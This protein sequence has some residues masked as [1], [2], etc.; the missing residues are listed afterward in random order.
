MREVVRHRTKP[1]LI[2]DTCIVAT[3]TPALRNSTFFMACASSSGTV[4]IDVKS[5]SLRDTTAVCRSGTYD[6]LLQ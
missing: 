2:A 3:M 5:P 6:T 4:G 1:S